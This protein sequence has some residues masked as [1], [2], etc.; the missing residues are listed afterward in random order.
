MQEKL[1]RREKEIFDL[2]L[3]DSK[4]KEIANTLNIVKIWRLTPLLQPD[5]KNALIS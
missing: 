2:L 5:G 4:A 3:G 1:T